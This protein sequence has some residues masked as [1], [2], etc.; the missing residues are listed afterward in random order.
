[1]KPWLLQFSGLANIP[2]LLAFKNASWR[3]WQSTLMWVA[4]NCLGSL[5]PIWGSYFLLHLFHQTFTLND[6]AKHGEFALYTA[7]FLAPALQQVV[8]NI[9]NEK[10]VLGT[11]AVLI[12]VTGLV[13][14]AIIYSGLITVQTL[15]GPPSS[16]GPAKSPLDEHFLFN[17]TLVIFVLSLIF[18][19]FV[20]LIENVV[21][22]VPA[23]GIGTSSEKHFQATFAATNPESAPA[24]PNVL[25]VQER[26]PEQEEAT[27]A[28]AFKA[29]QNA[30][31][32]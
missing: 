15:S 27:L 14:S 30:G 11:G 6:F 7:A 16:S 10:Y 28:S 3:H 22:E 32:N 25:E 18:A 13:V 8:R 24:T 9:K 31:G 29:S 5:M 12:S 26:S 20:T 21:L 4:Y 1:M 2:L 23:G 17:A 19:V